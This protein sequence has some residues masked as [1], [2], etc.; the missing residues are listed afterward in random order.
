MPLKPETQRFLAQ[1]AQSGQPPLSQQEP[2]TARKLNAVFTHGSHPPEPVKEVEHRTI[3]GIAAEIPLCIYTPIYPPEGDGSFPLSIYFHGGGWTIGNLPMVDSIC[4]TLANDA[5]CVVVSVD[6]RL[7]PEY[8]FP[9]GLED[10]YAATKWVAENAA[11]ING[12]RA[13]IA[14]A[15][16]SAGGNIAAA[17]TLMAR[18]RAE[19]SLHYQLLIYPATQYDANTESYRNYGENH[20]L[21]A[22]SITWFWQQYLPSPADGQNPYASPLLAENLSNLPP[23]LIV[24]AEY[25]PLRDEGEAYGDRLRAAGVDIK[26]IRYD[27]TIHGFINLAGLLPYGQQALAEIAAELRHALSR[28]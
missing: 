25:D 11:E 19:F 20:F 2:E 27:G 23:G 5:G 3:P 9:A 24:T 10:A 8:K 6:Y 15:G 13:K 18:A 26:T 7:A 1:V 22:D 4:R 16:E 28:S 12:D 17:V 14:V 21:T